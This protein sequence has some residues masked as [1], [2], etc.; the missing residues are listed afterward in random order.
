LPRSAPEMPSA[1]GRLELVKLSEVR[2]EAL[3]SLIGSEAFSREGEPLGVIRRI[4]A[5]RG[6]RAL[7]VTLATA[8]GLREVKASKV[9]VALGSGEEVHLSRQS[10][11]VSSLRCLVEELRAIDWSEV[12]ADERYAEGS[13]P[14]SDYLELRGRI[15]AKRVALARSALSIARRLMESGPPSP[16]ARVLVMAAITYAKVYL[17]EE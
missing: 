5:R 14:P 10:D 3:R 17:P 1:R 2:F 6:G 15:A 12:R 16:E 9:Y 8:A 13:L 4:V 7:R 11:P